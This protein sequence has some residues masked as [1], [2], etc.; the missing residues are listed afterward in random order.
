MDG[1]LKTLHPKVFGGILGRR[2]RDDDMARWRSTTSC[3]SSWWWSISI[4]SKRRFAAQGVTKEEAIEQID[5]GGP[6]LVRAAAKNH[7]HVTIATSPEQ[8]AAILQELVASRG[9]RRSQLRQRLAADAF[10]HTAAYD[11]AIADYFAALEVA[12]SCSPHR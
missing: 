11:R 2:D 7:A 3:R 10:A 12:A 5:I 9:P 1:R 6:S 4:R 8:Y